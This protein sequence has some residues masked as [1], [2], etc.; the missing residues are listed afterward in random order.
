MR[1]QTRTVNSFTRY[2]SGRLISKLFSHQ[3][4][5]EWLGGLLLGLLNIVFFAWA[6][7]PFTIYTGYLNWGQH[8]YFNLLR[9]DVFGAPS[10]GPFFEKTS[11]GDIGLFLG[12]LTAALL[13]GEFKLKI[14]F[15]K[16][17]YFE[18]AAGG[19]LMALGV[20]LAVGCNWGGFFSAIMAL[21]F[22]GYLM[23][24]GLLLGGF[25][26]AMY[27]DWRTKREFEKIKLEELEARSVDVISIREG[28]RFRKVAGISL[29]LLVVSLLFWYMGSLGGSVFIGILIMGIMV[30]VV[31]QRCRFCFA[32]A[33]R[34]ILKG[35]GEFRRSVRL[36][37]GIAL[38]I[39]VGASGIFTLKYMGYVDPGIYIKPAS[40][41]NVLGGILFGVGMVIAGGCASGTLWRAAEGHVKLW[42]ALLAAVISYAP[43]RAY[44]RTYAS[45]IYGPKVSLINELGWAGG[46]AFIYL[47]MISWMLVILYLEYKRGVK[48]G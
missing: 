5:P 23:F 27:I 2:L 35:G 20:V 4:W 31:H 38:G 29:I 14:P 26:G 43:L 6:L 25:I 40:W 15:R 13:A 3:G 36:Q 19:F 21:S 17:D 34:D 39:M 22:H 10:S 28:G 1:L 44:I 11:V 8:I 48:S 24:I 12:A 7:K 37:M 18:G 16:L 32:S 9:S 45:W 46:L 42:I 33:F 30:G 47:T 41:S